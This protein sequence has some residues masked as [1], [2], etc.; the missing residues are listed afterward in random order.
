MNAHKSSIDANH[1]QDMSADRDR[2]L[3]IMNNISTSNS[4]NDGK[5]AEMLGKVDSTKSG[6][7]SLRRETTELVNT[8]RTALEADHEQKISTVR[9]RHKKL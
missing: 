4:R 1:A 3:E 6:L 8:T 7:V 2:Q 9:C 5:I